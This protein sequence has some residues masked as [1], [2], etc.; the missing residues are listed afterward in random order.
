MVSPTET[1]VAIEAIET[2][3][4]TR[5]TEPIEPIEPIEAIWM[6]GEERKERVVAVPVGVVC[7][8]STR[9]PTPTTI[10]FT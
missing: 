10:P 8:K 5:A 4:G 3:E 2:I 7:E 1:T 9:S 6:A